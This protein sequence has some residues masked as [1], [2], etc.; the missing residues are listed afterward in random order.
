VSARDANDVLA[1]LLRLG[2][3]E[4]LVRRCLLQAMVPAFVSLARRYPGGG[5]HEERLQEVFVLAVERIHRLAGRDV[6]WPATAVAGPIRDHLRRDQQRTARLRSVPLDQA[7]DVAA[8]PE[9]SAAE[10]LAE[11]VV[12]GFRRG[13][14]G[15]EDAAL[16]YATRVVGHPSARVAAAWGVD[17]D[18]L[19]SRRNRAEARLVET[20]AAVC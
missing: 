3:D 12:D 13:H 20:S 8:G 1:A 6:P 10:R 9:R 14:L 5:D 15:R 17:A 16:L 2:T 4:P 7:D 11:V 18:V 19:R